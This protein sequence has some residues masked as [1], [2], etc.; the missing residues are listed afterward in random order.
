MSRCNPPRVV[1]GPGHTA[2]IRP[3]SGITKISHSVN[4]SP[5]WAFLHFHSRVPS[6]PHLWHDS[7]ELQLIASGWKYM[8]GPV[9]FYIL[10]EKVFAD[11]SDSS[12]LLTWCN[13]RASCWP[14]WSLNIK[15][16]RMWRDLW[17]GSRKCLS[18]AVSC[19][20]DWDSWHPHL[21]TVTWL[22]MC[23]IPDKSSLNLLFDTESPPALI[24][25]VTKNEGWHPH[26][27]DRGM[28]WQPVISFSIHTR[29]HL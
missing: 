22:I 12:M 16:M 15:T 3:D 24:Q 11:A 13:T 26:I 20:E 19:H 27:H 8:R 7:N 23:Q 4:L 5:L 14:V 18:A 25:G 10:V 28:I 6:S 29:I 9:T 21:V 2:D 1:T 17:Q